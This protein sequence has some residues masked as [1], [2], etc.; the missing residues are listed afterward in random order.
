MGVSGISE[1][2]VSDGTGIRFFCSGEIG[3]AFN[4]SC[5]ETRR[6]LHEVTKIRLE[7]EGINDVGSFLGYHTP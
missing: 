6:S 2:K 7:L 3:N 4:R 5:L 1:V